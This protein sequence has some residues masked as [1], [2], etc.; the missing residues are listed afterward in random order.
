MDEKSDD[1]LYETLY[2]EAMQIAV[3][4]P[5]QQVE[6]IDQLVPGRY[7]SRAEVVRVALDDLL[8]THR[9]SLIDDQYIAALEAAG[10][11]DEAG[12]LRSGDAEPPG[13]NDIPW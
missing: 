2:D 12:A 4:I 5:D 7:R 13:W 10:V 9:R 3:V 1:N 8:R 11:A 6:E